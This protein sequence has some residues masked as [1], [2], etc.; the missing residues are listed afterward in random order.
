MLVGFVTRVIEGS[1]PLFKKT[2]LDISVDFDH[3]EELF[4]MQLAPEWTVRRSELDSLGLE[5]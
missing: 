5:K 4:V 1:D 3:L 2:V